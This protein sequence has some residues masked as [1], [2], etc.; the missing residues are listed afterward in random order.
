M[1]CLTFKKNRSKH[2]QQAFDFAKE[3]NC[4]VDGD[5]IT[6][7]IPEE[8]LINAYAMIRTLFGIIQKWKGTTATYNGNKVNPYQFILQAHQIGEC[9]SE[10][11]INKN[12][13]LTGDS[14]AWSCNKINNIFY[15]E[16]GSGK[17]KTNGKY[18]YNYGYF[19]GKKWIIDKDRLHEKLLKYVESKGINLCPVFELKNLHHAVANLPNF[20][21]PDDIS[22]RIHFEEKYIKGQKILIPNNIRHVND[23]V[24]T[25][26]V[27]LAAIRS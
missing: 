27:G 3:L 5:L 23:K 16:G 17:Y 21:V 14:S 13:C 10:F 2:F 24:F 15:R 12:N 25:N 6:I 20:I 7:R 26:Y 22:Y 18:W 19:E 11:A 1:Y 9:S 8:L 4:D